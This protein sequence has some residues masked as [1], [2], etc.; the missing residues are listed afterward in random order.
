MT[1]HDEVDIEEMDWN[2]ELQAF[3]YQYVIRQVGSR[4]VLLPPPRLLPID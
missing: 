3:T 2:D 4:A 1:F